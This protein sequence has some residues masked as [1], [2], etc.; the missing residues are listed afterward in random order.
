MYIQILSVLVIIALVFAFYIY[1][2]IQEK[3][4]EEDPMIVYLR[5]VLSPIFPEINKVILMKGKKSYTINKKR[6][7]LCLLDKDG[8]YYDKHMLIYVT[9]H[10]LAHTI[11]T[12]VGHT[13]L[14]HKI[15]QDLLE[16]ASKNG[17]YDM[18]KPI[19]KDYCMY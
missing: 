7:H 13:D 18:N 6:V 15:F 14:F 10:E 3:Y 12:E 17:I 4:A 19:V 1:N 11:C 9:L 8:N 16:R 2:R 5:T